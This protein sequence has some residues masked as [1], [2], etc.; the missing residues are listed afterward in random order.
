MSKTVSGPEKIWGFK[1]PK[2]AMVN[3]YNTGN[4]TLAQ[5]AEHFNVHYSTVSR[6][7][8]KAEMINAGA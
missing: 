8:K 6:A 7:V 3:A 5:I 2:T 1:D 4:Y